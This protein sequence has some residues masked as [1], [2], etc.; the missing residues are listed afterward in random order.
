[1]KHKR[2]FEVVVVDLD[3]TLIEESSRLEAQ[4]TAVS[5]V[6]GETLA[7]KQ[8][9]IDAF[10]AANDRA[11]A[12]GGVS[13]HNIPQYMVWMGEQFGVKLSSAQAVELA[14]A[15]TTAY[16]RALQTPV[17]FPDTLPFLEGLREKNLHVFLATGGLQ[18][19]KEQVLDDAGISEFFLDIFAA[20]D[21]GYQKQDERFWKS[22]LF[23]IHLKNVL[24]VGNQINDDVW[25]PQKFGMGTVLIKRPDVLRK[26]LGPQDVVAD[27]EVTDLREVLT[28]L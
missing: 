10:F 19:Q 15:W 24:V 6:F 5:H 26:N 18:S 17:L 23:G 12:E 9:V 8:T 21:I 20:D 22:I 3:G 11:V 1:M 28:L 4:A 14:D 16:T 25:Q 13:K 27:Y 7:Q 2:T